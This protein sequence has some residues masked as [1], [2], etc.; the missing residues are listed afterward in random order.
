MPGTTLAQAEV[1]LERLHHTLEPHAGVA[2][3][4]SAGM[5]Q[6]GEG[7]L[8]A[9]LIKRADSALYQAKRCGRDRSVTSPAPL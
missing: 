1:V 9:A 7:E 8:L 5:A 6:A 2:Y 4:F 3:T